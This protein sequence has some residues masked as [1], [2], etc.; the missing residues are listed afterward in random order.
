MKYILFFIVFLFVF[1]GCTSKQHVHK[2]KNVEEIKVNKIDKRFS[3]VNVVEKDLY[4][5]YLKVFLNNADKIKYI[6]SNDSKCDYFDKKKH[7]YTQNSDVTEDKIYIYENG[8]SPDFSKNIS[9]IQCGRG[10]LSGYFVLL[11]TNALKN[12]NKDN[13]KYCY[14]RFTKLDSMQLFEKVGI[15]LFT[16]GTSILTSGNMHTVKFDAKEF[17]EA[18]INSN[19]DKFKNSFSSLIDLNNCEYGYDVIYI[20]SDD[21]KA[22]LSKA[23]DRLIKS[24]HKRDGVVFIDE[25]TMKTIKIITFRN[26]NNI[27]LISSISLQINDLL[28][29]VKFNEQ[30][31]DVT[32]SDLVKYIPPKINKPLLPVL[33]KLKKDEFETQKEFEE[34]V[35]TAVKKREDRIK[36]LQKQYNL[37]ILKRNEYINSLESSYKNYLNNL[38][39]QT[40][41]LQKDLKNSLDLLSQILFIQNTQ[42]FD[43]KDFKYNTEAQRLYFKVVTK[44]NKYTHNAFSKIPAKYAKRIKL[45]ESFSIEP[46]LEYKN[47][48]LNLK[49]FYI[50]ETKSSNRYKVIYTNKNYTPISQKVV[51]KTNQE[52]I[53]RLIESKKLLKF[54]QKKSKIVSRNH[55]EIWYIDVV[56]RM[57]EKI[58]KWFSNPDLS[59]KQIAYAQAETLEEA[60]AKALHDLALM[61]D[62]KVSAVIES[63]N[64]FVNSVENYKSLKKS[65]VLKTNTSFEKNEYRVLKQEKVDGI[66]YIALIII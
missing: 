45:E 39:N 32:Y 50:Y 55:S 44:N 3:E 20:D 64:Q 26:Y 9:G 6:C 29:A 36:E 56:N 57:N 1:Q 49:G 2:P 66:W 38:F 25:K 22:S 59:E 12:H 35:Y 23:Y 28:N 60:K 41:N 10:S 19:L 13:L 34:R 61:N 54:K 65:I 30:T 47:R 37:D 46:L 8:Y 43:A 14:N 42:G 53:K 33:P 51:I 16:F 7:H 17:K 24:K 21:V 31:N 27:N 18:I 52:K 40:N 62:A 48:F 15:S 4:S 58:P 5:K 11:N 63:T